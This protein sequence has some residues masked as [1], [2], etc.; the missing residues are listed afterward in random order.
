MSQPVT[1]DTLFALATQAFDAYHQARALHPGWV[2]PQ[3]HPIAW[4]GDA[5]AF[6]DS[7]LRV[8]TTGLNPSQVEFPPEGPGLR[9]PKA[10]GATSAG[11]GYVAGLNDYF[12]VAAYWRWFNTYT[13]LLEGLG[14]PYAGPGGS[15]TAI[16]TDLLSPVAT[17]PTWSKLPKA[18]TADLAGPGLALWHELVRSLRPDVI[19]LSVAKKHLESITLPAIDTHWRELH[20]IEQPK[21]VYRALVRRFDAD[22]H[23]TLIVWGQA[24]QTPFGAITYRA[25][26]ELGV[27][28]RHELIG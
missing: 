1:S 20:T 15:S 23:P 6:A 12:R 14:A 5:P 28:I 27:R 22:G 17:S 11:P 13:S 2:T 18:V 9:F 19:L 26:Y 25:R 4:F 21:G 10:R 7:K 3:S 8:M 24:A 16:H